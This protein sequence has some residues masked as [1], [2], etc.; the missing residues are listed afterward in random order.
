MLRLQLATT[1]RHHSPVPVHLQPSTAVTGSRHDRRRQAGFAAERRRRPQLETVR[2][3]E[4]RMLA[5]TT[6]THTCEGSGS[7]QQHMLTGLAV[8]WAPRT[9]QEHASSDGLGH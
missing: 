3:L 7:L 9:G 1:R 2:V 4:C 6:H 5:R 8:R